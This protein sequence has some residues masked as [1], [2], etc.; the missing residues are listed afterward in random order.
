MAELLVHGCGMATADAEFR[1]V[2]QSSTPVCQVNLAFNRSYKDSNGEWQKEPCFVRV[3]AWGG[4][5]EQLNIVAK[6]GA[7]LYVTGYLKQD[8]WQDKKT[9]QTRVGFEIVANDFQL[10][11]KTSGKPSPA[12]KPETAKAKKSAEPVVEA[13]VQE[14]DDVPF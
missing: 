1:Y 10:C 8:T 5:A 11:Q 6:K 14:E 9:E 3:V 2:G 13:K 12:D 7:L 4:R